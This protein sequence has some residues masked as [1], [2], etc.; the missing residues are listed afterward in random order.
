MRTEIQK[1][2][3]KYFLSKAKSELSRLEQSSTKTPNSGR[4]P[5]PGKTP[6]PN[7]DI[8]NSKNV[9]TNLEG[10]RS[11]DK[12]GQISDKFSNSFLAR[13]STDDDPVESKMIRGKVEIEEG[14][15]AFSQSLRNKK[16]LDK[17]KQVFYTNFA[18]RGL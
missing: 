8:S 14:S 4:T 18:F 2:N 11:S 3:S 1:N 10:S 16:K 12:I 5:N 7:F 6:T 13:T 9:P 15:P 17:L